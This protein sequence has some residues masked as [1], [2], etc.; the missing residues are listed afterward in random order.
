MLL[1]WLY[2]S[3]KDHNFFYGGMKL[4]GFPTPTANGNIYLASTLC[5][6]TNG[7]L[8]TG[9]GALPKILEAYTSDAAWLAKPI[10]G[11][12]S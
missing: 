5:T 9:I 3:I 7:F 2:G 8:D 11:K 4:L 6:K 1:V 10:L 12:T